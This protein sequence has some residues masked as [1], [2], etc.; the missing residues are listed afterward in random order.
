[1]PLS[2]V[3]NPIWHGLKVFCHMSQ[4]CHGLLTLGPVTGH[5]SCPKIWFFY[6]V[7]QSKFGLKFVLV[8]C[9][10]PVMAYCPIWPK[11]HCCHTVTPHGI[12]LKWYSSMR[13]VQCLHPQITTCYDVFWHFTIEVVPMGLYDAVYCIILNNLS[14]TCHR[15]TWCWQNVSPVMG[16][17]INWWNH[18]TLGNFRVWAL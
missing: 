4:A 11:Y 9:H 6:L 10:R 1:M 2:H 15:G 3:T 17:N 18:T 7:L 14:V 16:H 13:D 12:R 5:S 8:T